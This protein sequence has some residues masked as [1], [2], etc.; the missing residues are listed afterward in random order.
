MSLRE[1]I[2]ENPV[3]GL[4]IALVLLAV[5]AAG[6]FLIKP[7]TSERDKEYEPLSYYYDQNKKELFVAPSGR[8]V[9]FETDS[10]SYQG[11][12][13]AVR[14]HV[15]AC[16]SCADESKRFIGWL[17]KPAPP[18]QAG[19]AEEWIRLPD[20]NKWYPS[21]SPEAQRIFNQ[22]RQRCQKTHVLHC[23]PEK[24]GQINDQ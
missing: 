8:E 14:A 3:L 13:A 16:G 2:N 15:F 10:G 21:N 19:G 12:P 22:V 6:Y 18:G 20:Q 7:D 11:E 17:S 5:A 23:S 9:P 4:G 1:S 24:S